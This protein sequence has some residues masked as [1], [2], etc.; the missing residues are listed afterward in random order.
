M[1]YKYIFHH[2]FFC[3][4]KRDHKDNILKTE[5][6]MQYYV[7]LDSRYWVISTVLQKQRR[8]VLNQNIATEKTVISANFYVFF[9]ILFS[10]SHT[11]MCL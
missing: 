4:S 1:W 7:V 3:L 9:G 2:K 11:A 6:L 8:V 5:T 10:V